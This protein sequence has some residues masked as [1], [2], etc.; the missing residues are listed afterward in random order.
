MGL[1]CFPMIATQ[2]TRVSIGFTD[3]PLEVDDAEE[4]PTPPVPVL[5]KL[6]W[7]PVPAEVPAIPA[8]FLLPMEVVDCDNVTTD[9]VGLCGGTTATGV[10]FSVGIEAESGSISFFLVSLLFLCVLCFTLLIF[11]KL[12]KGENSKK[13]IFIKR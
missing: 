2:E 1:F 12:L 3:P 10:V 11:F 4:K 5:E 7:E 13:K 6:I 9:C 8:L